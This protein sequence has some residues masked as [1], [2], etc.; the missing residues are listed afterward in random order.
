MT[1]ETD[2]GRCDAATEKAALETLRKLGARFI[3]LEGKR[4]IGGATRLYERKRPTAAQAHDH[5]S[6]DPWETARDIAIEPASL[7]YAVADVDGAR[8]AEKAVPE[9]SLAFTEHA[10][11]NR[12]GSASRSFPSMSGGGKCHV[13]RRI[14]KRAEAP[15][16]LKDDGQPYRSAPTDM[17]FAK[18]GPGSGTAFDIRFRRSY[19]RVTNYFVQLA[20]YAQ[21]DES[22]PSAEW[23]TLIA[24][25]KRWKPE[26]P[27]TIAPVLPVEP[28]SDEQAERMNQAYIDKLPALTEGERH[29]ILNSAG[30]KAG[31]EAAWNPKLIEMLERWASASG[32]TKVKARQLRKAYADG[33]KHPVGRPE[34]KTVGARG[35]DRPV[36][37]I[38]AYGEAE[39]SSATRSGLTPLATEEL[40]LA[41]SFVVSTASGLLYDVETGKWMEFAKGWK[42]RIKEPIIVRVRQFVAD[43]NPEPE[44]PKM[45]NKFAAEGIG[46]RVYKMTSE[47]TAMAG[48][49]RFDLDDMLLGLPEGG[50]FEIE[51]G[52]IRAAN[53]SDMLSIE[54]GYAPKEGPYPRFKAFLAETFG[55][56]QP[57][58]RYLLRYLGYCLT[59]MTVEHRVLFL[60]GAPAT[61]KSALLDI[62]GRVFGGYCK[63]VSS[64]TFVTGRTDEHPTIIA[65]LR[66]PRLVWFAETGDNA[67][68]DDEMLNSVIAGD[69]LSG[70]YMNKDWFQ[71]TPRC[72]LLMASNFRP[73]MS[74]PESGVYRRLRLVHFVH[75]VPPEK[76][77]AGLSRSIC[78]DEGPAILHALL[79]EAHAWASAMRTNANRSGLLPESKAVRRETQRYFDESDPIGEFIAMYVDYD[80]TA[81]TPRGEV[82]KAYKEWATE[83]GHAHLMTQTSLT[84]KLLNRLGHKGVKEGRS[85]SERRFDGMYLKSKMEVDSGA[86]APF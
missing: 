64:K 11:I 38:E 21:A 25:G 34:R 17:Y 7:G 52:K 42:R 23:S 56:D 76:R 68:L 9:G 85:G 48:S 4:P 27:Q 43:A 73:R 3:L 67:K 26:K 78:E 12:L 22:E 80:P 74:G 20:D 19:V 57:T 60:Q 31:Q 30:Y 77:V 40:N 5:L 66:G 58:I 46:S 65:N 63:S 44:E 51:S 45:R 16:G 86:S 24:Y 14:D 10:L 81:K 37:P 36:P 62:V 39:A 84:R 47:M 69:T 6:S 1:P 61:G 28:I 32:I 18:E 35:Q 2:P 13:W 15:L 79:G 75:E 29:N 54:T 41:R 50:C 70:R 55:E 33:M 53:K 59:G 49:E 71:F 82:Y 72:K 83:E 8:K